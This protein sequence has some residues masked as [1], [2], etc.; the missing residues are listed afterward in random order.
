MSS[1]KYLFSVEA[2]NILSTRK[3]IDCCI[4]AKKFKLVE[5]GKAFYRALIET[6]RHFDSSSGI[7]HFKIAPDRPPNYAVGWNEQIFPLNRTCLNGSQ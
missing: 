2:P 1:F 5:R 6:I 3:K 4:G 7:N